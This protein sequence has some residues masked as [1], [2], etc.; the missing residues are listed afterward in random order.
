RLAGALVIKSIAGFLLQR[1][2]KIPQCFDGVVLGEENYAPFV[3]QAAIARILPE[4]LVVLDESF[5]WVALLDQAVCQSFIVLVGHFR[6]LFRRDKL[7]GNPLLL[8][9]LL[10]IVALSGSG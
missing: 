3:E 5:F 6:E 8:L 1:L 7:L 4:Q 10:G 2:L 9:D